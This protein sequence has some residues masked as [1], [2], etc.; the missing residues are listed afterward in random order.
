VLGFC[1]LNAIKIYFEKLIKS[2]NPKN[3]LSSLG[4]MLGLAPNETDH[5]VILETE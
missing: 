5:D 1:F 3:C 4:S 2:K